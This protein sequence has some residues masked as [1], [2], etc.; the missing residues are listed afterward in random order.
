MTKKPKRALVIPDV[1]FPI[2][3]DAAV[4]CV[5]KAIKLVKPEIF[6]CLGDLGEW[7]SVSP[8]R[9]KRRKRPPLEYTIKDLVKEAKLVNGPFNEIPCL[10]FE[11]LEIDRS[12]IEYRGSISKTHFAVF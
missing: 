9:Y 1:H 8:W 10:S 3:D 6:I 4:N 5:I 11:L 12:P 7:H 2:Q